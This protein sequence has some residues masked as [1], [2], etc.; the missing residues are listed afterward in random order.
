MTA[1]TLK[2][3]LIPPERCGSHRSGRLS[4]PGLALYQWVMSS[5]SESGPPSTAAVRS[6]ALDIGLSAEEALA[7]LAREDLMHLDAQGEIAVAYP[8][9]GGPTRHRVVLSGGR[10]VWAMC[11]IDALGIAAMLGTSLEVYSTDPLSGDAV[12][13]SLEPDGAVEWEPVEAVVLAGRDAPVTVRATKAAATSSTSSPRARTRSATSQTTH[14]WRGTQSRSRTRS[15]PEPRSSAKSSTHVSSAATRDDVLRLMTEGAQLV[16]VLPGD[17]YEDEHLP[18][19]INIP[20]KEMARVAPNRLDPDRPVI[21]Y[22]Y[23][24]T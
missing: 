14:R 4:D 18:G 1:S 7:V 16:E 20:L 5:F 17:E 19:A 3:A 15:Q 9:S 8:F 6:Y 22:C 13:V 24:S 12:T 11:A 10:E 23:D 21:V 2:A